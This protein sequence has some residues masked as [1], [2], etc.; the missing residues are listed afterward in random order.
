VA[1]P[2]WLIVGRVGKPHGVHGDVLVDIDTDFPERLADGV[3]F[4]L[5]G[6]DG[7][8]EF[9]RAF[10]VRFH[11]GR[12]LLSVTGIRDREVVEG[13]RGRFIFLPEQSLDEL[14]EGYYYEHHLVGLNAVSPTGEPLGN[15]TGIDRR[16][17]QSLLV[18]R[19]DRRE[20]LVPYVPEIVREVDLEGGRIVLDPPRGLLDDDALTAR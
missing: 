16:G 17:V 10:R 7:P 20:F 15:V 8:A 19:R 2:Q 4:G 3:E 13:W 6:E 5:G 12:W 9:L 18:V 14:P 1:V 11:R